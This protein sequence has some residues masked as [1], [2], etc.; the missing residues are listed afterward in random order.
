MLISNAWATEAGTAQ[1]KLMLSDRVSNTVAHQ[2]ELVVSM[3]A[4]IKKARRCGAANSQ[5]GRQ[6][7]ATD[8]LVGGRVDSLAELG[9]SGL[10]VMVDYCPRSTGRKAG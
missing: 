3:S 5:M 9:L 2:I 4:A 6:G 8:W 1:N 10:A 7:G